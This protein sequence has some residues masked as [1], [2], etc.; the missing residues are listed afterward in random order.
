M[1]TTDIG[2]AEYLAR[3]MD[4]SYHYSLTDG[5]WYCWNGKFWEAKSVNRVFKLAKE[6][7]RFMKQTATEE[8]NEAGVR[9][10][11]RS[12][13]IQRIKAMVELA[14]YEEGVP[15]NLTQF[16]NHPFLFNVLNGTIDLT[17]GRLYPHNKSN[18]LTKISNIEYNSSAKC[19]KW[20]Q[21]L[22]EI[23]DYDLEL[24]D[25]VQRAVGYSL[26]SDT[27]EQALFFLRGVGQNGKSLFLNMLHHLLGPYAKHLHSHTLMYHGN[28]SNNAKDSDIARMLGS[29]LVTAV[30]SRKGQAWDEELVKQ[31]TG[32]D[33][34]ITARFLRHDTFQFHP[35][36]K[37]WFCSNYY[38]DVKSISDVAIWRRL[39]VIG[40]K[41]QFQGEACDR[42]LESKLVV[43]LP[44]VLNWALQGCREWL[45]SGLGDMPESMKEEVRTYKKEVDVVGPFVDDM[46]VVHPKMQIGVGELFDIY[47]RWGK[48]NGIS[49][50]SKIDFGKK[51]GEIENVTQDRTKAQRF[52]VGIGVG[53]VP[54]AKLW[55][56]KD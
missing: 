24:I 55:D 41:R 18:M 11:E 40:F 8:A 19:D 45:V 2:N 7:L 33:S 50:I 38:P 23:F 29:R 15:I 30:E 46:C 17:S 27:R 25:Y 26:T 28:N 34:A 20:E 14:Q 52:W 56:F 37:T 1:R 42:D 51:I 35:T 22:L 49:I 48:Q 3:Q 54:A 10:A 36:W 47:E 21:T 6:T 16:D 31:V 39:K 9:W 5:E 13:H 43:E 4:G 12:E 44:G 53:N 32:K